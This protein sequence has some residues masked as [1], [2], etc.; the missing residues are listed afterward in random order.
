MSTTIETHVGSP[1]RRVDGRLKVTGGARYAAEFPAAGLLHG[2]VVSG[3][4]AKG[5]IIAIDTTAAE[6][7][8]GVVK[9]F[10]HLNRPRVPAGDADY[11]DAVAPPGQPFRPLFDDRILYSGQ[12]VAL[13]VAEDFG[14]ARYAASLVDVVVE[15]AAHETDLDRARVAAYVPPEKRQGIAPPPAPRGDAAGAFAASAVRVENEYRI[16]SEHHNPMEP[17]ASTVVWDGGKI[18]VYDKIQGVKN[19]QQYITAVFGLKPEDVRVISPFV[20]GA[21]GI[22]LR[23]QY[24][25]FLAVMA[26]L[27][28]KRP[29]RV[30]LTR[31]QMFTF[32]YRPGTINTVAVGADRDGRL[33]SIRHEAVAGTSRFEDYQEVV[34]NWSALLYHCDNVLLKYQIAK[35]DTYTPAD[36]RAP[37]SPLGVFGIESAIDELSYALRV[38]PLALR[39]QNYADTDENDGKPFTSRELVAACRQGAE[40]FG[41]SKRTPE[42]GSMREGRELI[43]WGMATGIWEAMMMPHSAR[44]TL[45]ADGLLEVACATADIGAGTYTILTQIAA[46]ALGLRMEDVTARIGDSSLPEA[47]VEGGSWTAASAGSAVLLACGAVRETLL[48]HARGMEGSPLANASLEHVEFRG[49]LIVRRGA[50]GEAV[51][52]VEVMRAAGLDRIEAEETAAPNAETKEK[53]S[54]Y[55]HAA[56]FAE[57]RVDE[58]LGVVRVTRVVDAVAA[59]SWEDHQPADGAQPDHRRGGVRG[60]D[61]AA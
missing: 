8:P 11:Q 19:S 16:A 54:Q 27:D 4:V 40:R 41:W 42:P 36:M 9:V 55:T 37:G 15:E 39:L 48:R 49:G 61:G 20:G 25:L 57:V 43:G 22:G 35:I 38:D 3:S 10:T 50:P 29:V 47:P 60:G 34:V 45:T 59:G 5:R 7:V 33:Q 31:A 26:A 13:V 51:S 12:P 6:A 21:F 28:L 14:S 52:I 58:E 1:R 17:H 44:A 46:D 30:E 32:G 23:P 56:V 18:V 24:Q 53:F 2:Y